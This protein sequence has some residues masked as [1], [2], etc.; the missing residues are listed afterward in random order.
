[1]RLKTT[2]CHLFQQDVR[3]LGHIVSDDGVST[4]TK[5][6]PSRSGHLKKLHTFLSTVGYCRQYLRDFI[7]DARLLN[8]L[9]AKGVEWDWGPSAQV[10]V[11]KMKTGET[12]APVFG[13][14][15]S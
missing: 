6:H 15:R 3:Y 10:A 11:G 8:Q 9:T 5:L 1:M 7:R 13:F 12:T 4:L 2:K 14:S